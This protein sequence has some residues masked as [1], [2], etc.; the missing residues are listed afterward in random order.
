MWQALISP[1]LGLGKQWLSNK[2][3]EKQAKHEANLQRI[4][5]ESNWEETMAEGSLSSLKDEYWTII[6]SLPVLAVIYSV[7]TDDP[8]VIDK[9]NYAFKALEELPEWFHI[10][11]FIA[12]TAS[13][14]IRGINNLIGVAKK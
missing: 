3:E 12:V 14:G 6:L 8:T 1:L 4:Q 9:V 2:A 13:F 7:F 5:Q 11:L 10:L